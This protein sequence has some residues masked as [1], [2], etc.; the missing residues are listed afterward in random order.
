[1]PYSD[2]RIGES[3]YAG[4]L[5]SS[6]V[7]KWIEADKLALLDWHPM[8]TSRCPNCEVT[9]ADQADY[10][11]RICGAWDFGIIPTPETFLLFSTWREVFDGFPLLHS[12]AY[13]A[14]RSGFG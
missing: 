9:I 4:E 6:S 12:P 10:V 7:Q 5:I 3:Y 11:A 2:L 1:M 8:F 14:F 13:A